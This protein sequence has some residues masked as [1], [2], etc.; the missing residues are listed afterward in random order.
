MSTKKF[1]TV[2]HFIVSALGH[3]PNLVSSA[4]EKRAHNVHI[5]HTC[6]CTLLLLQHYVH[7][8]EADILELGVDMDLVF[9]LDLKAKVFD[10][11]LHQSGGDVIQAGVKGGNEAGIKCNEV[12]PGEKYKD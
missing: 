3:S 6:T 9:L 10:E 7:T 11:H 8:Y 4:M 2:M 5:Q 12:H 1:L